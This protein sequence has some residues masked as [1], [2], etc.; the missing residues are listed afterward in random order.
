MRVFKRVVAMCA[1]AG[2]LS[3]DTVHVDATLIR[4]D[5]SWE[6]IIDAH[7]REVIELNVEDAADADDKRDSGGTSEKRSAT[8]PDAS[9]T[10]TSKREGFDLYY[11]QHT[12]V[13]DKAGVVVDVDVTTGKV[14][15]GTQLV[16]QVER[17][18]ENTG[19]VPSVVTADAAYA[20]SENYRALEEMG[21]DPMIPSQPERRQG[22]GIPVRRFKYDARHH[23]VRCPGGRKM[24]CVGTNRQGWIFKTERRECASCL[25]KTRC[26]PKSKK[27]RAIL[28]VYGYT[29]LLR[30]RRKKYKEQMRFYYSRH[31]ACVEGRNGEAK[32]QHGL[33][34]A[35]R[36]GLEQV[37]IQAILTA[38]AMNLKRLGAFILAIFGSLDAAR[39]FQ[40][41]STF[42]RRYL[43]IVFSPGHRCAALNE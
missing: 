32:E 27:R 17:V 31:R 18:A 39:G 34:R 24:H 36:R 15:E 19:V 22:R 25:L 35:A 3:F 7:S 40:L 11:K 6:S 42:V 16:A 5:A 9:W 10:R 14:N 28:I 26:V 29:A 12:A 30:G 37:L 20:T 4:A 43:M 1:D 13:D 41:R 23:I 38:V 33:R 21:I 2:L 8:D